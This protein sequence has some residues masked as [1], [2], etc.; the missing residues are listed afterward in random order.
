MNQVQIDRRIQF[1]LTEA[2]GPDPLYCPAISAIMRV[3][4]NQVNYGRS[5]SRA[6]KRK[7]K[8]MSRK[9]RKLWNQLNGDWNEF[10][11]RTV[12]EHPDELKGVWK[13]IESSGGQVTVETVK[14]RLKR[15]CP[16]IITKAE[17]TQ[18][19]ALGHLKPHERYK[20]IEITE[21]IDGVV[22]TIKLDLLAD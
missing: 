11:A 5:S 14:S 16:V 17:D 8:R 10:A 22:K 1:L 15:F 12:Y 6:A 19:R 20:M 18:M 4:S 2:R 3:V 9:A 13:W 21:E 7:P